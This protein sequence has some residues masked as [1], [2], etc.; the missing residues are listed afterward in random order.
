MIWKTTTYVAAAGAFA[1]FVAIGLAV[2]RASAQNEAANISAYL[3]TG[4]FVLLAG[5][6]NIAV[7]GERQVE[8]GVFRLDTRTGDTWALRITIDAAGNRIGRWAPISEPDAPA[9]KSMMPPI[10][11][12]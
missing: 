12:Q 3:P 5:D 6:Y 7:P 1:T 11:P 2:N 4:H 9:M 10:P 8:Q